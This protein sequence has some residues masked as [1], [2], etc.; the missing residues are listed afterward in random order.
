MHPAIMNECR[1]T[2]T[3]EEEAS[4]AP[5]D[6]FAEAARGSLCKCPFC[7]GTGKKAP[8]F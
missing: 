6:A 4:R 2:E 7:G 1:G 8:Y 3:A 5:T